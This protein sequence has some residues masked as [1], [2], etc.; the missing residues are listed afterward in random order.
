MSPTD[1]IFDLGV[2]T[3]SIGVT[4]DSRAVKAGYIFVALKGEKVDGHDYIGAAVKNGASAVIVEKGATV[5][6]IN[7]PVIESENPSA[8]TGS[9]VPQFP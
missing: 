3:S 7:V 9:A 5:P 6:A 8:L 1:N 2:V 4:Q